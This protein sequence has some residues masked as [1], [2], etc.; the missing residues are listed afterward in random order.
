MTIK[1]DYTFCILTPIIMGGANRNLEFRIPSIKG[2]LRW[3]FRFYYAGMVDD[4]GKLKEK[5]GEIFGSTER[6]CQFYIS[7]EGRT[8]AYLRMNDNSKPI[9]RPAYPPNQEFVLLFKSPF[10]YDNW[11]QDLET[12]LKFLSLFGGL[13]ARWRRG[14]GS[15]EVK[16]FKW[17]GEDLDSLGDFAKNI[18]S[19][20]KCKYNLSQQNFM[21]ITNTVVYIVKPKNGFWRNWEVAMNGLRD[22]FYREIKKFLNVR[23]ISYKP[24]KGQ[25]DVSPVIIQ[26]KRADNNKY[27]GVVLVYNG[28]KGFNS[29]KNALRH[30]NTLELK[31]V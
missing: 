2:I 27:F 9:K 22:N 20:Y 8:D 10:I 7:P 28:W 21:N 23:S 25:R 29:F 16:G 12:S 17:E 14:F 31:E 1:K 11:S 18:I 30:L 15:V 26:I 19:N 4:L 5:E 13:G 24:P 3:W 6:A